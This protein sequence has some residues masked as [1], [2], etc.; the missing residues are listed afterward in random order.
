MGD[1]VTPLQP[2]LGAVEAG[3]TNI[4]CAVGLASGEVVDRVEFPTGAPAE[5]LERA[6]G[7]FTGHEIAAL[8]L[9]WFGPIEVRPSHPR[10]GVIGRSPKEGWEGIDVLGPFGALGSPVGL[11]TDVAA[12]ALGEGESGASRGLRSHV[13]VTVGTGIGGAAV[14][15]AEVLTGLGHPEMGHVPVERA[16]GDDF[17]GVCPF[18]GGCLEGLASGSAVA[19][20]WGSPAESLA[21]SEAAAAAALVTGYLAQGLRAVVYTLAPERI[22]VGGGVTA[23]PG[24]HSRLR[25]D[26]AASLA[27]YP[28]LS[29]H[30]AEDFVVAPGLGD[31]AGVIGGLAI[32]RR[33][34]RDP[35]SRRGDGNG[36]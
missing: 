6:V 22:V 1:I 5:T 30:E 25:D 16:P 36:R 2:R 28:G 34:G 15:D 19:A 23:L 4:V 24:F 12:A 10:Y 18:H 3:G 33:V 21:E 17:A 29:E 35:R 26:L 9:G 31:L 13:Y 7:Y 14:V 11:A 8:G 32:A 27:G 20:R